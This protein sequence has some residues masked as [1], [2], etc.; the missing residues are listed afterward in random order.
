MILQNSFNFALLRTERFHAFVC[1]N[2]IIN[3]TGAQWFI[4]R[5]SNKC[6]PHTGVC[7]VAKH[8]NIIKT[9]FWRKTL[10]TY[11][12]NS[13][14]MLFT[15]G[16]WEHVFPRVHFFFSWINKTPTTE[17]A[18]CICFS[19][20]LSHRLSTRIYA[21]GMRCLSFS[22]LSHLYGG[23]GGGWRKNNGRFSNN[24]RVVIFQNEL[25]RLGIRQ[26]RSN[27]P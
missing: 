17:F 16:M 1:H 14:G 3:G 5:V 10:I 2:I 19:C 8:N 22:S 27:R 13:I 11:T 18:G 25:T 6:A 9:R 15:S 26:S 24:C 7:R 20:Q 4:G 23:W 12:Y 21:V